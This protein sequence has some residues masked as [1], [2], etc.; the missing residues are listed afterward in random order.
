M[1]EKGVFA[2]SA[3][4]FAGEGGDGAAPVGGGVA[5]DAGGGR[6]CCN[7]DTLSEEAEDVVLLRGQGGVG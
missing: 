5:V 4:E 3:V 7:G 6:G 2:K 1:P